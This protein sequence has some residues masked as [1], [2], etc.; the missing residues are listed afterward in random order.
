M[1]HRTWS[2]TVL[3]AVEAASAD[4]AHSIIDTILDKMDLPHLGAGDATA[5]V[6][7]GLWM[8]EI[9]VSPS[10]AMGNDP[11]DAETVLSALRGD[12]LGMLS[13][14]GTFDFGSTGEGSLSGVME[15]PPNLFAVAGRQEICGHPAVRAMLLK[16]EAREAA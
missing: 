11:D 5:E 3:I 15:W 6:Q 10:R 8:A 12:E 16:A 13:W 1:G 2:V 9:H 7:D 14:R 4:E